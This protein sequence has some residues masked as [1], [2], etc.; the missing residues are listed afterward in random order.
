MTDEKPTRSI[1]QT[2]EIDAPVEAVWKA[3]AEGEELA[4]WFAL[5]AKVTP[6]VGGEVW[7]SWPGMEFGTPITVWEPQKRLQTQSQRGPQLVSVDYFLEARGGKTIL[8][9]VQSGFGA[10]AEWD[11]EY[12]DTARGWRVFLRNLRHYLTRHRG[13]KCRQVL[14]TVPI[15]GRTFEEAWQAFTRGLGLGASLQEGARYAATANNGDRLEGVVGLAAPPR[16]LG[17]TVAAWNDAMLTADFMGCDGSVQCWFVILTYDLAE[18]KVE[19]IRER[20]TTLLKG[21]FARTA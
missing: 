12:D 21:L 10:G 5:D 1:E 13:Q 6:G 17:A 8:R 20:W 3:I 4:K 18:E 2:I 7:L 11:A 16:A 9:L 14:I 19:A 15:E